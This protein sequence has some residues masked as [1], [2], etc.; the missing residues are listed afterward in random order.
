MRRCVF[1]L[2]LGALFFMAGAFEASAD[3]F[4]LS[5]PANTEVVMADPQAAIP[6]TVTNNSLTRN[7]RSITFNIDTA[8]YSF[9]AATVPPAGWCVKSVTSGA[10]NF[11]L[12]QAGG[13]CSNGSTTSQLDPGESALFNITVIPVASASDTADGFSSVSVSTQSGFTVS[14][15]MPT[16]TRRS[17]DASMSATPSS[18]GA[19]SS[20]TLTM[21]VT[22]R[23]TASK[24]PIT[25]VPSPPS[26][27]SPIVTNTGGPF[28]SSALL[29]SGLSLTSTT[30]NVSSTADFPSS[31]TISIDS[32]EL[33]YTGKTATS[34][35]GATRGCNSTVASTH[36]SGALAFGMDPFTL[37]PGETKSI[38]WTYSADSIGQVYFT[39]RATDPGGASRS[40]SVVSNTVVIGDF[41][42][43]LV[44]TPSSVISGQT[45]TVEMTVTNN[46]NS[47]LVNV[48]PSLL[49]GCAGGATETLVSGPN[50]AFISSLGKG[51]SGVFAW[52]YAITGSVGQTY[53]LT[54]GASANGPVLTNT[55]T[56]NSGVISNY[57]VSVAPST[58][59]SGST[60]FTITWNVYNGGGCGLREAAIALPQPGWTCSSVAAPPGWQGSCGG[61]A[62][63]SSTGPGQ[64]LPSGSTGSFSVTFS[65]SETVT[66]DKTVLFP[67]SIVPRGCGGASTTLGSYVTVS[68]HGI[69][70][71]HAPA[72][73]LYADGS[74][75]YTLTATLLSGGTPVSGKTITF[76]ATNGTLSA[77]A[78]V[79]DASGQ[80]E[81]RLVAPNSTTDV[82]SVVSADYLSAQ[83]TDTL[84]FLGWTKANLQYWGS[85][86]PV[87]VSCGSP[88]TFTLQLRNIS[89]SSAMTIGTGSY[90][91]FN[92]SA[93]GG[94]SEFKAYL[95]SPVT[96]APGATQNV[97]FGSATASGGGGGVTVPSAFLA[98][99]FEPISNS[100]PPPSSGLFLT[101]GG[102]NDQ[103][104]A[105]TDSVTTGGGC[106]AVKVRIID[107]HEMR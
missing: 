86:T 90:L 57:S 32:E 52:T 10:I 101:D 81:V 48:A 94:S 28:Y 80:A 65:T 30:V 58:V 15:A 69:T 60:N 78:A 99:S 26:A 35:T 18:T 51:S 66:G 105:V 95:D 43:S 16:W 79:T 76:A 93:S 33:C 103:Y 1:I 37:S 72:G 89:A 100:T 50:P 14:G 6:V 56:S 31:G 97:S 107:W 70:L 29:T 22:N 73:P 20:I 7:I 46:G 59:A 47:A 98:G 84:D 61:Q 3:P 2:L 85:L 96:L 9:S 64:D 40:Q 45:V 13:S 62:Q 25:S 36:S 41:T 92:D 83:D 82:S 71:T 19:G 38:I 8:L 91:A 12:V 39:G 54:G 88:Y 21:Q 87:S 49:T 67:V 23:S 75:Y 74:S 5:V 24:S 34:F 44:L 11:E 27:S 104:R 53:C 4:S 68:A 102:P 106:G 42:A 55:A 17:L 77:T 63:F